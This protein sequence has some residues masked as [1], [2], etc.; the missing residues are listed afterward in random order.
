MTTKLKLISISLALF[1]I[2]ALSAGLA[3][4]LPKQEFNL[5]GSL[6]YSGPTMIKQYT[7][8][9][10][11]ETG[12]IVGKYEWTLYSDKTFVW[13]QEDGGL[14]YFSLIKGTW[15]KE[16]NWAR[17][18]RLN[19][20]YTS[21]NGEIVEWDSS[22][23]PEK[24]EMHAHLVKGRISFF[25]E[26]VVYC[27]DPNGALLAVFENSYEPSG[28]ETSLGGVFPWLSGFSGLTGNETLSGIK[29]KIKY[30]K[31]AV[32]FDCYL[33]TGEFEGIRS[34]KYIQPD[35]YTFLKIDGKVASDDMIISL[36]THTAT[37]SFKYEGEYYKED[38]VFYVTSEGPFD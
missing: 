27:V 14:D 18:D 36:G 25:D 21:Q 33:V 1:L 38:V 12:E 20:V 37:I 4:A 10:P 9:I 24:E 16:D 22:V 23:E 28:N 8:S 11:A 32:F 2:V 15:V 35:E 17:I 26:Y 5:S 29:D 31:P 30:T 3:F 19:Y 7:Y 13:E 34:P 6:V